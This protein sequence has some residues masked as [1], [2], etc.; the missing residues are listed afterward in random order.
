M[1]LYTLTL[2]GNIHLSANFINSK[3]WAEY[4]KY[5]EVSD[6]GKKTIVVLCM[7]NALVW[8]LREEDKA[9][10]ADPHHDDADPKQL[11]ENLLA[12]RV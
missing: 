12:G 11:L 1:K 10:T 9:Y 7:P 5:M 3:G 8:K 2:G 6:D 4:V